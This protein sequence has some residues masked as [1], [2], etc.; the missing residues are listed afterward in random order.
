MSSLKGI[1]DEPVVYKRVGSNK[2]LYFSIFSTANHLYSI[3]MVI[4][5][6]GRELKH[7][8]ELPIFE[9]HSQSL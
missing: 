1:V 8:H 9:S 2:R 4:Y 7:H 3:F 5:E 6:S